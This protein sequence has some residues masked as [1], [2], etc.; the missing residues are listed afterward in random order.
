MTKSQFVGHLYVPNPNIDKSKMGHKR[1][2][3]YK[4]LMNTSALYFLVIHDAN[5]MMLCSPLNR[6]KV[7]RAV[8]V[9]VHGEEL[10]AVCFDLL[11]VHSSWLIEADIQET[12][13]SDT[14]NIIYNKYQNWKD[15]V[16]EKATR[17]RKQQKIEDAKYLREIGKVK[18]HFYPKEKAS[19]SVSWSI[20]HP[21]QGGRT[22]PK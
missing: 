15:K 19:A 5:G 4:R 8:A 12:V 6:E 11:N 1:K 9:S 3:K 14:V 17:K 7:G 2:N 18:K 22:S 21:V 13:E 16:S 20:S 10:Y